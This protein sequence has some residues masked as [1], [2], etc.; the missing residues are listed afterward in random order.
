MGSA[1]GAMLDKLLLVSPIPP[2]TLDSVKVGHDS[3][4]YIY[5]IRRILL[6]CILFC[7]A[8]SALVSRTAIQYLY[9]VRSKLTPAA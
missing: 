1:I 4:L 7:P 5:K 6:F 3:R 2:L 8:Q 9:G